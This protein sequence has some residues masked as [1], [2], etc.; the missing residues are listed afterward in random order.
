MQPLTSTGGA[1]AGVLQ[2]V[3]A[4]LRS[5]PS[6]E[7]FDGEALAS[8]LPAALVDPPLIT[9]ESADRL[10]RGAAGALRAL[11]IAEQFG[12]LYLLR[13]LGASSDTASAAMLT[14]ALPQILLD[15]GGALGGATRAIPSSRG[16]RLMGLALLSNLASRE[17]GTAALLGAEGALAQAVVTLGV[18]ALA[19][20]ADVPFSQ[21]GA[22]LAYNL[23][24]HAPTLPGGPGVA[25][26][27][28]SAALSSLPTMSDAE[29][30][31]RTLS[32]LGHLLHACDEEAVAIAASLNA[33]AAL[34]RLKPKV[35][36]L[37]HG[38]L[39]ARVL[40]LLER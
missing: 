20:S 16:A 34:A 6:T 32:V 1:T 24:L 22:A 39:L 21:L 18:D 10:A 26:R 38:P 35:T 2:K 23:S 12:L 5:I 17:E 31:A 28:L 4:S 25:L 37:G 40:A 27:L 29:S 3:V 30:L 9:E 36:P 11:P 7:G 13:L 33:T 14:A 15:S 8:S 19:D